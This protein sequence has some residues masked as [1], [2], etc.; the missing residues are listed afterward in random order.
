MKKLLAILTVMTMVLTTLIVPTAAF[1][2]T[3]KVNVSVQTS[4]LG[5][6]YIVKEDG[7]REHTRQLENIDI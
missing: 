1:G 3:Q 5:N 2:N 4:D 7:T 6:L